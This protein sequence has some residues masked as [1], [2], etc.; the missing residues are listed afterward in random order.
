MWFKEKRLAFA[1]HEWT[2]KL[3]FFLT[4]P[5]TRTG[6]KFSDMK[7]RICVSWFIGLSPRNFPLFISIVNLRNHYSR[8]KV[9]EPRGYYLTLASGP[10]YLCWRIPFD[11]NHYLVAICQ[12]LLS[13]TCAHTLHLSPRPLFD[14]LWRKVINKAAYIMHSMYVYFSI[15]GIRLTLFFLYYSSFPRAGQVAAH[16]GE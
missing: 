14:Q 16:L 11:I 7:A 1:F 6:R 12:N 15:S 3:I 8:A 5:L 13:P 10:G 9:Q 4:L 2:N